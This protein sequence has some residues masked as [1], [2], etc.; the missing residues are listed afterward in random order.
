[1]RASLRRIAIAVAIVLGV[2][3]QAGAF[4][5]MQAGARWARL[6]SGD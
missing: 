6:A 4:L 3:V 2:A 5:D 1:M